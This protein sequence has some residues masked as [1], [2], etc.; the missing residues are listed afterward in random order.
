MGCGGWDGVLTGHCHGLLLDFV[1]VVW[2]EYVPSLGGL[3]SGCCF[4][5]DEGYS[6]Q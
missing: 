4:E 3:V 6:I 2:Y 1:F 5:D